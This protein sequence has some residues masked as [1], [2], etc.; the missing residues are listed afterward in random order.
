MI[1]NKLSFS[2]F[3]NLKDA[4]IYPDSGINIICGDNA[5]GKT[6]IIEAIWLFT[7]AKSFKTSKDNEIVKFNCEKA[8]LK[9][10]FISGGI[11]NNAEI[12]IKERRM[13]FFGGK[14]LNTASG[15]AGNF[16]AFVFSRALL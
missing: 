1:I 8:Q 5:Q 10:D 13:A 2:G 15:L 11:E 7:G 14:K 12:I 3:R 6:N 4:E 16:Y 9:L